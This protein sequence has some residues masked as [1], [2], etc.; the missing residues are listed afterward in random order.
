MLLI[1]GIFFELRININKNIKGKL[2]NSRIRIFRYPA[3]NLICT[4]ETGNNLRRQ[5]C[6]S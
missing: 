4:D 3:Q 2:G 6:R 5:T 1:T